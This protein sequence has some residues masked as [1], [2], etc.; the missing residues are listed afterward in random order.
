MQGIEFPS[1]M[2]LLRKRDP[3]FVDAL[4]I[5]TEEQML[6]ALHADMYADDGHFVCVD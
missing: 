6:G 3:G 2:V 4:D 5:D 1:S